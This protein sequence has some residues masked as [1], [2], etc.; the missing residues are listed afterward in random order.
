MLTSLAEGAIVAQK[1]GDGPP[2][3]LA[4]HGWG[5]TA[6]DFAPVLEGFDALSIALPG[7]SPAPMPPAAW[8]TADY[9]TWL[10]QGIDPRRPVVIVG[11]SFGGRIAV[12][13]AAS[14]PELV[15]SLVLTGVPFAPRQGRST[16]PWRLR[17]AKNLRRLG[18]VSQSHVEG[19]R[20]RYGSADYRNATGVMRDVLVKAVNEDYFDDLS[21]I[22]HHTALVWGEG[23]APAPLALAERA[24]GVLADAT[25]TVVPG[26]THLLDHA[27]HEA[28]RTAISAALPGRQRGDVQ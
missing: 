3:V 6:G 10:A 14:R 11:H 18:L 20:R 4:L 15:A 2:V 5:R 16:Q 12:R 22:S 25:L 7:F 17:L 1:F 26:S 19:M 24:V 21:G 27:L 23:D 13:L 9:A 28:L 8:S